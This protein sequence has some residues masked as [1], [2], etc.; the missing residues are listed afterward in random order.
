MHIEL[1]ITIDDLQKPAEFVNALSREEKKQ[2]GL[3]SNLTNVKLRPEI[4]KGKWNVC[5]C[6]SDVC[7][8]KS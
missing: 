7:V 8:A 6:A 5:A 1:E 3:Q 2:Q 4:L